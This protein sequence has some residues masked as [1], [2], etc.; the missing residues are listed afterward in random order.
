MNTPGTITQLI[1]ELE[2]L[3]AEDD[4]VNPPECLECWTPTEVPADWPCPTIELVRKYKRAMYDIEDFPF[5]LESG[6]RHRVVNLDPLVEPGDYV[7]FEGSRP[8]C[9]AWIDRKVDSDG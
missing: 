7:C 2:E 3:H 9:E 6:K 1:A 5:E 4:G 8:E